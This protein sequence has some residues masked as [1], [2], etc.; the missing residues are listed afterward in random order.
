[1]KLTPRQKAIMD[2][3]NNRNL[4]TNG[5][6]TGPEMVMA[7][8]ETGLFTSV[9]QG[10][11]TCKQL[12]AKGLVEPLGW[13]ADNARCFGPSASIKREASQ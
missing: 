6:E 12:V 13:G 8:W 3:M 7:L 5:P 2:R 11:R 4:K 9:E 1:M 10:Q